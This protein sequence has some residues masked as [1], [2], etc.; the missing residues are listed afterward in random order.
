M[1]EYIKGAFCFITFVSW[2]YA[3]TGLIACQAADLPYPD[4]WYPA[5]AVAVVTFFILLGALVHEIL[6]NDVPRHRSRRSRRR[7]TR[8]LGVIRYV[9]NAWVAV[10]ENE[11]D[12]EG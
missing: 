7:Q 1:W 11:E 5:S 10:K 3:S 12:E 6:V 4:W 9:G 2:T 8:C